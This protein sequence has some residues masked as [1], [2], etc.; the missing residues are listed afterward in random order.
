M[1]EKGDL[2]RGAQRGFLV[3]IFCFVVLVLWAMGRVAEVEK[4]KEQD[5]QHQQQEQE[6]QQRQQ[7]REE[8]KRFNH[9]A[10]ATIR[11]RNGH[12]MPMVGLG[13]AALQRDTLPIVDVA[14][15][16]GYKLFDTA[17]DEAVWYQNERQIGSFFANFPMRREQVF[18][19]T[20][21]HPNQLGFEA[22]RQAIK[23][24]L[25]NLQTSYIDLYLI[26]FPFCFGDICSQTPEGTWEDS[27]RAIEEAYKM[28]RVRAIGKS[29]NNNK[30]KTDTKR[31]REREIMIKIIAIINIIIQ[32]GFQISTLPI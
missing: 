21:L 12:S 27:W 28:G 32:K 20:K 2:A 8:K 23:T 22:T 10:D 26:H 15:K 17:A 14:L 6:Q 18:F 16:A 1:G 29:N 5:I 7:R 9:A 30:N 4:Q 11:L 3:F 13:T 19:T 25:Q 31:D 24:S